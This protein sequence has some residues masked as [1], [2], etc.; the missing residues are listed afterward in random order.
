MTGFKYIRDQYNKTLEG[1]AEQLGVSK[2]VVYMW[3][4]GKKP[5]PQK[6]ADQL[7]DMLGIPQ[8]YFYIEEVSER[9]QLEIK[10]YR[11][12]KEYEETSF[13]YEEEVQDNNGNW[14]TVPAR[15]FD[16]GLAQH[17]EYNDIDLRM[18]DLFMKQKDIIADYKPAFG[19]EEYYSIND[20]LEYRRRTIHMFDRFADIMNENNQ[21]EMLYQIMRAME[22]FF[23]VN[24]KK[25][26]IWGE[27]PPFPN[28]LVK[29]E[30]KLVQKL[31][32]ILQEH[33]KEV[34]EKKKEVQKE[35]QWIAENFKEED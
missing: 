26:Q 27:E 31:V 35:M 25:N 10:K 13:Q 9:D 33:Y 16:A 7:S 17:Q 2:Q 23:N 8:K 34:E 30:A 22:L 19:D 28:D 4:N 5:I 29:D 24:V 21:M 15:Y 20:D 32:C 14:I 18:S 11:L 3:E 12:D 1:L 6:R